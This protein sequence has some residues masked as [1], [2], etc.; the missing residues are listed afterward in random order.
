MAHSTQQFNGTARYA[1]CNLNRSRILRA[2]VS[3]ASTSGIGEDRRTH[4]NAWARSGCMPCTQL[5]FQAAC[6][7]P[8]AVPVPLQV[9][10]VRCEAS[11]AMVPKDKAVKR[12]I[13]RNIVD[14]SA[15]RDIQ[16]ASLYEGE[17]QRSAAWSAGWLACRA[18]L[19]DPAWITCWGWLGL[20][21]VHPC[22]Q[23]GNRSEHQHS[24]GCPAGWP[25][26]PEARAASYTASIP[27]HCS[28]APYS[29]VVCSQH[30]HHHGHGRLYT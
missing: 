21:I 25:W 27:C 20:V 14:A 29:L 11:G 30:H 26:H 28:L 17:W 15:L 18:L 8:A 22:M 7:N 5:T 19:Q 24:T 4:T 9:K 12:F 1:G 16:D 13:V 6:S 23:Q 2:V 10:R 3:A